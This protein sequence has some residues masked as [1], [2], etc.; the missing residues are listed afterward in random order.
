MKEPLT[1]EGYEHTK[2]LLQRVEANLAEA[3]AR[4]GVSPARLES[5]RRSYLNFINQL[6]Q[7][8]AEYE[9]LNKASRE[10]VAS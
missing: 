7:E 8:I 3:E 4:P 6:K 5:V 10:L 1:P 2:G 9:A